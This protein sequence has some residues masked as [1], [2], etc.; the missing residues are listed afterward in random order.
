MRSFKYFPL[1]VKH[2]FYVYWQGQ[3][4]GTVYKDEYVKGSEE[5]RWRAWFRGNLMPLKYRTKGLAAQ[6]LLDAFREP[7]K[8]WYGV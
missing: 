4:I 3:V 5:F 7:R 1:S 2:H 6:A 8:S